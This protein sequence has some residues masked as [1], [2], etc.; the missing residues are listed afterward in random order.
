MF[1]DAHRKRAIPT[2]LAL[3]HYSGGKQRVQAKKIFVRHG[4]FLPRAFFDPTQ[5]R[6]IVP[7]LELRTFAPRW[8][9]RAGLERAHL[10]ER[11]G[12]ALDGRGR[13]RAAFSTVFLELR[14]PRD[15]DG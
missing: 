5:P 12:I 13:V 1:A 6:E 2:D 3:I 10:L 8:Q 4:P 15:L 9:R 11:E 14:R 7:H